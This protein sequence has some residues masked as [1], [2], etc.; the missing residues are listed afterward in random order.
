MKNLI[1]NITIVLAAVGL[2]LHTSSAKADIG[3]LINDLMTTNRV[4]TINGEIGDGLAQQVVSQL[5][6]LDKVSHEPIEIDIT[7]YGGS[8]YSGLQILDAMAAVKSPI[9]TVCEGYCMSMAGV[10]LAAGS[11]GQRY[12]MPMATILLHQ[13]SGGMQGNLSAMQN[14]LN[15]AKRLS[16]LMNSILKQHTGL[17]DA[18]LEEIQNHDNFMSPET[19]KSL[20][21]ID[22]I[23]GK[24]NGQSS[25]L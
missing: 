8:V 4:I 5:K 6:S 15:E 1:K 12:S 13:I 16:V 11:P 25:P 14:D 23:V 10:I 22:G 3:D 9:K 21:L 17:D 18:K 7:S 20:H 24:T 2:L 19:A